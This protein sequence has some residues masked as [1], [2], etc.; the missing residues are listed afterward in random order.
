MTRARRAVRVNL[1][2][3]CARPYMHPH[4]LSFEA[5]LAITGF[6]ASLDGAHRRAERKQCALCV[7]ERLLEAHADLAESAIFTLIWLL[8][9]EA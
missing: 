8:S 3:R 7:G 1:A 4:E 2:R 5:S 6:E 9:E